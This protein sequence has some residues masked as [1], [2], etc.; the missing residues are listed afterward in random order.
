MNNFYCQAH[1]QAYAIGI[2]HRDLSVGNI[3]IVNGRGYLIDWDFA[4]SISVE[5]PRRL[6]RTVC[7]LYVHRCLS[8]ERP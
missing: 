2:L 4:K 5:W 6:T 1:Q 7:V 8:N 3:I